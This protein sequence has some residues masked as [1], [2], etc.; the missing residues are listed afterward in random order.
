MKKYHHLRIFICFCIISQN[1]WATKS[2]ISSQVISIDIPNSKVVSIYLKRLNDFSKKHCAPGV[3]E[4]FWK[5][6]K[7]F[8]GNGNF[9]PLLTNGRLD[10]VTVNRFIPELERKQKWI[11][12]Q[13]NY[14]KS[15]KNFKSELEK[16]KKLEK[17]FKSLLLYKRDYFLAKNQSSKNKIRNASKYQYIVFR[18][19][20]KEL[21]ESITF[22]QSY[23]FPV[24]H[25]DLRISYDQFKSSETVEGKSKSNEIYFYRKIVQDGAQNLNHKKSDRFLRAT[26]DSI[27]LKLNEKSDFIT[28]DSRYDLSAAFS[29]IKWHLNS[30]IKHQLTRLG[31]WHKRV[32]RGLSFYKKL[33]DGKIEEKGHSFSAKNL[34][35]ERAKG[36]YIL[37]DYVLK[38]EADV[39]RYWMN[40]STLLQAVYV[41]DTILF[42]EVG[43]IDGRDALERKDVT[44]VIINRLSD[45]DYNLITADE[46][47]YSYLKLK[48][49]VIAKNSWLNVMLK[50]GEFSFSYFFIP[51]NLRIY[52]P[53]MTR[54][55]KFLRR[56]NISMAISLLQKPNDQ[57]KAVRYF[58]RASMLGR[59]DMSKIW[60]NFRA[61]AERPGLPSPRSHYL[62]RQYR[63]GKYDF[64]YDFKS[65][66]GKVFQVIKIR[67]KLYVSDKDGTRFFKYRNRHYFKYFET[68]L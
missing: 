27:Y 24:D 40:Q 45:P 21:I 35:E 5:K 62:A 9:I 49:K 66:E 13:I 15:K 7:V 23:R 43:G 6:Y 53:D 57:F 34:L 32:G 37:K 17:E 65:D 64:L 50:E 41:I 59:I 3:E 33:R 30:R 55:G 60:T 36:R 56:E 28:E 19:Q 51:G 2:T 58:S 1:I 22:L 11:F 68:H 61:V 48:D 16:F 54:T 46:S 63:A 42:N 20:L 52:C 18:Q 67:K 8:K 25:F 47:L 10:K 14:L 39:Y 26:I 31:E 12:S 4:D 44:Q 38:K 29:A